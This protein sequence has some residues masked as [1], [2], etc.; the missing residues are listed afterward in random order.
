M[1]RNRLSQDC[2]ETG[3]RSLAVLVFYLCLRQKIV[4]QIQVQVLV[5]TLAPIKCLIFLKTSMIKR[6][7]TFMRCILILGNYCSTIEHKILFWLFV[8]QASIFHFQILHRITCGTLVTPV[9]LSQNMLRQLQVTGCAD[10]ADI[11]W[12]CLVAKTATENQI[13]STKN[14]NR[15]L[16]SKTGLRQR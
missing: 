11:R 9:Q 6:N 13:V 4:L 12:C 10:L 15:L 7:F 8:T 1:L 3:L 5:N 16:L 2:S 14:N